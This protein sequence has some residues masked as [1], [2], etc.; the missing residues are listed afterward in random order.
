MLSTIAVL[1]LIF[2]CGG[3]TNS[4]AT[5][6][7][8]SAEKME[9]AVDKSGPEYTSAYVCPMHCKGSGSETEGK[10][11]VCDMAYVAN[12]DHA[13]HDGDGHDH[14]HADDDHDHDH[15]DDDH[16]HDHA[17]DDHDHDH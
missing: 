9:E 13:A 8:A 14:D 5:D 16:D 7:E 11:P 1:L 17:D 12:P 3:Q 10:C 6:A 4:N 2:S 15:A